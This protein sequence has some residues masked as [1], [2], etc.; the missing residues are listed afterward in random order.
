MGG[1]LGRGRKRLAGP[2]RFGLELGTLPG[3]IAPFPCGVAQTDV[4]LL[5]LPPSPPP[6]HTPLDCLY[7]LPWSQKPSFS[8]PHLGTGN[9][10]FIWNCTTRGLPK[11]T[12]NQGIYQ[13]IWGQGSCC[14][15]PP[16]KC[17]ITSRH[18]PSLGS[19]LRPPLL[20]ITQVLC[21]Q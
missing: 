10:V 1:A 16:S 21:P 19:S 9:R 11:K 4:H 15:P 3:G 2:E 20:S 5:L 14:S 18:T 6:T 17:P 7:S 8:F 13:S 12:P